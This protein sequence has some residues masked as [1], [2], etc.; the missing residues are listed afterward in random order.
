M[1]ALYH[2]QIL[3]R[4]LGAHVS[5]R[6]LSAITHANLQQDDL[7]GLLFHFEYH[8][9]NCQFAES[10]RYIED[11]RGLAARADSVPQA[12]A[13]FGRL[14]HGAQDFYAH[15]NYVALWLE[16]ITPHP[17]P[18]PIGK[19]AAGE[20]E[21]SPAS[22]EALDPTLLKHPRLVS[23]RVA[24]VHEALTLIEPL[25]PWVRRIAPKDSHAY[26]NLDYPEAGP[27]FPYAMEAAIQRTVVEYERTVAL[28]G[29][30]NGEEA[31]RAFQGERLREAD[32]RCF[33]PQTCGD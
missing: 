7:N 32:A 26:M 8:F 27:F 10:L 33:V 1:D 2:Q 15:S 22:I 20:R 30:E 31:V 4:A 19:A 14:T 5:P 9:D 21:T 18:L 29:E 24:W 25:R 3:Q 6:A 23:G 11:Q 13:A 16:R 12:W 17:D 28:M